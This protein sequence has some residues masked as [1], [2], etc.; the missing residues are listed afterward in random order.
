MTTYWVHDLDPVIFNLGPL[1]IRWYGLM[2]VLGL[3]I[4]IWWLGKRQEKG[5]FALPKKENIQDM[6]FYGFLGILIGGRLGNCFLYNAP[7]F[8]THPIDIIKVWEGG[9]SFHGG[10][11]GAAVGLFIYSKKIKIP[12]M[13]LLDNTALVS[14][15]GL[16]LGRVAN[17]INAE[18]H[19]KATDVPWAVIFPNVD[20]LPRHPVQ[21]YQAFTDG[22]V[23]LIVMCCFAAKPR[24]TGFLSGVFGVTYGILRIATEPFRAEDAVLKGFCGL[25]KGQIY[26]VL[27]L[28]AGVLLILWSRKQ[29][30]IKREEEKA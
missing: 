19:G 12:F 29:E 2:Y 1:A 4:A 13:H 5:L 7:Y 22:V 15:V 24:R 11:V 28:I 20:N 9:M 21:L 23:L 3:V 30:V 8:L 17:F 6:A 14:T 18:L 16:G 26:S 10:M 25:T 27:T